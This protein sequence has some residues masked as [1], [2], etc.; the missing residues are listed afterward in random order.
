MQ[1]L[2][3]SRRRFSLQVSKIFSIPLHTIGK[4]IS[5]AVVVV[6]AGSGHVCIYH[7]SQYNKLAVDYTV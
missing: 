3:R 4:G 1:F 7:C 6:V 5:V 2:T